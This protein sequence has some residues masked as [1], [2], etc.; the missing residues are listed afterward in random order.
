MHFY[1]DQKSLNPC[2]GIS[3]M[4]SIAGCQ[5]KIVWKLH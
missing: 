4:F 1:S 2:V 3:N 5:S